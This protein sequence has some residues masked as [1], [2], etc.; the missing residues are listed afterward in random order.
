MKNFSVSLLEMFNSFWR[1][2]GLVR[3]LVKR[4]VIG[5]YKGSIMGILWSFLNPVF[6]LVVYTFVF[7]VV[8]KARWSTG[9]G[10]KTEFAMVLFAGLIVFNLFSECINR[11]PT[12]IMSNINYVKKVIFPLEILAFV[13]VGSAMFHSLVSLLVWFIA[14]LF[15]FGIPHIT[16]LML[17]LILLPLVLFILGLTWMLAALG[18][19]LRDTS[20]FIGI[21][22]SALMFMSPVF[23]PATSL[24]VDYRNFLYFNPLTPAIE[25]IR[26]ILFWGQVP[27]LGI[28]SVFT[29]ASLFIAW[30]G[31]ACFQKT[32]RGFADVL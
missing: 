23:Y 12:L 25:G 20:Q 32:R 3:V 28:L 15:L 13:T 21:F 19:F 7:S 16:V 8:F 11:A 4:E 30:I 26:A 14:Y 1:N 17:P 2:K 18:V 10:S 22:T 6:M 5:R 9:T 24:P 31:F 29:I 27:N